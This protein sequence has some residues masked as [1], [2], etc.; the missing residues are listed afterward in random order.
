[1]LDFR[2]EFAAPQL[3]YDQIPHSGLLSALVAKQICPS[4]EERLLE[5]KNQNLKFIAALA[6]LV[7]IPLSSSQICGEPRRAEKKSH[8]FAQPLPN[9]RVRARDREVQRRFSEPLPL[10]FEENRGQT[11][12]DVQFISRGGGYT[13]FLTPTEAVMVLHTSENQ[14]LH[15]HEHEKP[16]SPAKRLPAQHDSVIRMKLSRSNV[17]SQIKGTSALSGTANYFV[18]QDSSKWAVGIPTYSTVEYG[19]VYPGI[20]LVY[21]GNQ[22]HLEYDFVL[23]PGADSKKIAVEFEGAK[24]MGLSVDGDLLMETGAGK[25]RLLRPTIYQIVS[26]KRQAVRGGYILRQDHK[27]GFEIG[28]YDRTKPLIVDPVLSFSTYLGG[29]GRD[30]PGGIAADSQGNSYVTG[31]TQSPDFPSSSTAVSPASTGNCL[32]Y[33]TKFD[34]TGTTAVYSTYFGGTENHCSWGDYGQG[35]AVDAGGQVYVAGETASGDFPVTTNGFQTA[36]G[37]GA[38]SNAFLTKLSSDG[39]SLLYSTYLG[40]TGNDM[41]EALAIDGSGNAYLGGWTASSNFPITPATAF[42]T[43]LKS[44][45]ANGFVAQIDTTRSGVPS[46]IYSSFLGGS[47]AYGDWIVGVAKGAGSKVYLAS[48]GTS[49]DFPLTSD[50]AFQTYVNQNGC[51]FVTQMDLSVAGA[52]GLNYSSSL[53]GTGTWGDYPYGI[54]IDSAENAYLTGWASS[55]DFPITTGSSININGKAF[56]SKFDSS[57]SGQFSMVYSTLL[58]GDDGHPNYGDWGLAIAIDANG[59]AYVG[60]QSTSTDFPITSDAIQARLKSSNGNGFLAVLNPSGTD[61]LFSTYFG[62]DGG[63][64]IYNVALDPSSNIYIAGITYSSNLPTTSGAFQPTYEGSGDSF[65][66]KLTALAV[67]RVSSLSPASGQP[68]TLVTID[69]SDFGDS[70]SVTFEGIQASVQ[71]WTANSIV[72][73]VPPVELGMAAV[74]VIAPIETSNTTWF[75]VEQFA[76]SSLIPTSG[77]EGTQVTIEGTGF[78]QTQGSSSVSFDGIPAQPTR[79]SDN[80]IAVAVPNKA[81]TGNVIVSVGGA[82][83]NGITFAVVTPLSISASTVPLANSAGWYRSDI[84]VNFTCNSQATPIASCSAPQL[85]QVEG[86]NRTVRGTAIDSAGNSASTSIRV[87]LDRTAPLLTVSS[88]NEGAVVFGPMVSVSGNVSDVLSGVSSLTCNG[89]VATIQG[90]SFFCRVSLKPGRNLLEI[91]VRDRAGNISSRDV[92]LLSALRYGGL[93]RR[94]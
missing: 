86:A 70:G 40:G 47:G 69:G 42:Q 43:T 26:G 24:S 78:G 87:N 39:Q 68:S 49:V 93:A 32:A 59:N 79:W 67:P 45:E 15:P 11:N 7:C 73:Q 31:W 9:E 46:L 55:Q 2:V 20:D 60:G 48:Y 52:S 5:L 77:V 19:Q 84:R 56:V 57:L 36:L 83:S 27:I 61:L 51:G 88:P 89:S 90:S 63:E 6:A 23:D 21:Y 16:R 54:A 75:R 30:G 34:P 80:Q 4:W 14:S 94:R 85:I 35:I 41:A 28:G 17:A 92:H 62:G 50:T 53:C 81:T 29:T 58:G 10:Q 64:I 25:L 72:V 8:Q 65:V 13:L 71:S 44:S 82:A 38:I 3:L 1:M 22:R 74:Q 37:A 18:G 91:K 76:V 66:A 33:A 12:P